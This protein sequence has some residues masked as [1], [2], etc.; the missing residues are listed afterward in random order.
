[1]NFFIELTFVIK[2]HVYRNNKYEINLFVSLHSK[3]K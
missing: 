3:K 1:M 2:L